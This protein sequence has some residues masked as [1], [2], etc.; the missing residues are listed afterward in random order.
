MRWTNNRNICLYEYDIEDDR[1]EL[2]F[3][4]KLT[5]AIRRDNV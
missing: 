3:L 1:T 4:Y 2:L 5:K